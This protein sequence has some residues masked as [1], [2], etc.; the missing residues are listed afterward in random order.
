MHGEGGGGEWVRAGVCVNT[1]M[2]GG[3]VG[4][5]GR[6]GIGWVRGRKSG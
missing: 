4:E 3:G 6:E 2:E 1:Y 5:R